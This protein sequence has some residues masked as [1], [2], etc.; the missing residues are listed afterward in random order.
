MPPAIAA[1]APVVASGVGSLIKHKQ[2]GAAQKQQ[3]E[4][5]RLAAQK[6]D[7]EAKAAWT[8]QQNS[9]AARAARFKATMQ[10]G[11]L[12]G[13]MGGMAKV[14]PS[15]AK[16]YTTLRTMP[17]YTGVSSYV[18]TPEKGGGGWDFLG[19]VTEALGQFDPS[20][21]SRPKAA[22][23]ANYGYTGFGEGSSFGGGTPAAPPPPTGGSTTPLLDWINR[24]KTPMTMVPPK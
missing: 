18:P 21:L 20:A 3:E 13:A 8:A 23:P 1:L 15:M 6:A 10:L 4:E 22:R 7:E 12:A 14:P 19:G 9:P 24:Q 17:E 5:R 11:R 2:A 16:Y